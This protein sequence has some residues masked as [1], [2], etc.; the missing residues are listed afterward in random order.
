MEQYTRYAMVFADLKKGD[1][2]GFLNLFFERWINNLMWQGEALQLWSE[3]HLTPMLNTLMSRFGKYHVTTGT[4]RSVQA[5]L[6]QVRYAF[7]DNALRCNTLPNNQE[8]AAEFDEW[9]NNGIRQDKALKEWFFP[10]DRMLLAWLGGICDADNE[11]QQ[12]IQ[13]LV[14]DLRR[15]QFSDYLSE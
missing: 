10:A 4:D 3:D 15:S 6:N 9:I 14:D 12:R 7:E 1:W 8:Q 2:E 5:H 13:L 11:Q